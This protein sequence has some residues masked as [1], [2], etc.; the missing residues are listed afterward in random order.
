MVLISNLAS[1]NLVKAEVDA[2][3]AQVEAQVGSYVEERD[4][5]APLG[6]CVEGLEQV[7]GALRLVEL[8]GAIELA[9]GLSQLMR[10]V[11]ANGAEAADDNFAAL[12]Q[13]IM[14]LGRYLEYVQLKQASWPQLLLPAINQVR[15]S[16]GQAPLPEGHFLP[17]TLLPTVPA[18]QQLELSPAQLAGLVRRLRLM[19]QTGLIAVLRDQADVPHFRMMRRACERAQ[20]V[21]GR[22]PL[23][24]LWWVAAAM[25]EALQHGVAVSHARKGLLG[26][27]DRQLKALLRND[28]NARP[29]LRL[30]S[31]SLYVV[32]LADDGQGLEE[33]REAFG[34]T[35]ICLTQAQMTTEY[36]LMCGPGGSVI[37]TVAD[38]LKDELAQ[39]KD[40]LDIM[41]R[42]AKNDTD[43]YQAMADSL[44]RT[45]QTLVMLGLLDGS[46]AMRRQSEDVRKWTGEPDPADLNALVDALM[47]V[48]N[49]VAGLVR[50]VTPG[51]DTQVNNAR[52]SV[53]Q[54]DEARAL[55]VAES[56]SGLSLAKRAVSSYVESG[57]D[58]MH[59]TNVPSTL[60]SVAGG[61][62]FLGIERGSAVLR[63]SSRYIEARML[64]SE[65]QPNMADL[66]TLADAISSVDYFLESLEANKPIGESILEIAEESMAELGFPV[67]AAKA[68]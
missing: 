46:Q 30:V 28:G 53:H 45:S 37:K 25:L 48:E 35:D 29:D 19:Y 59:L 57:R 40:T 62:S 12:G 23:A 20:Q 64:G 16:L 60:Q 68:A 67:D 51:T 49:A 3:L 58:L 34:L 43:S 56:R 10:Q 39:V 11:Q 47:D 27:F 44:A 7:A 55:L 63:A 9:T 32:G 4:N 38:V 65:Q 52:I 22:R 66:E 26:Q 50:R 54:L 33:V 31:D 21:C 8:P 14:V 42:G 18:S 2:T 24:L 6:N 15:S 36:E 1:L 5:P 13:G 17:I 41:S 61:L